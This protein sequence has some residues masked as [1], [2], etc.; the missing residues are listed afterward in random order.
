MNVLGLGIPEWRKTE[1][2]HSEWWLRAH[3]GRAFEIL[4]LH[5]TGYGKQGVVVMRRRGVSLTPSELEAPQPNEPR[6]IVALQH[7]VRQLFR[8]SPKLYDPIANSRSWRWTRP[9]RT[10]G[11]YVRKVRGKPA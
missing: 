6:E 7:N 8:G 10:L 1:I 11:S 3:W 9:L 5:P 4:A 2:L